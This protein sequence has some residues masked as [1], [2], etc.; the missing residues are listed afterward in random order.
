MPIVVAVSSINYGVFANVDATGVWSVHLEAEGITIA[1]SPY[2]KEHQYQLQ[3]DEI[4]GITIAVLT[5]TDT[6]D[7]ISIKFED[8]DNALRFITHCL[9]NNTLNVGKG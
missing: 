3:V 5:H 8:F 4:K 2:A 1:D 7:R 6:D 9:L